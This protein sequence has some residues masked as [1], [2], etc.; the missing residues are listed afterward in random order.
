MGKTMIGTVVST[1]MQR[2]A[3][4]EVE[5]WRK[6]RLYQ[7]RY[8]QSRRFL[9]DNPDNAYQF[10]DRVEIVETRPLSKLKHWRIVRKVSTTDTAKKVRTVKK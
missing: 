5:L 8:R 2:T 4:V 10:G 3:V 1:K 9:V 6:H 7:K